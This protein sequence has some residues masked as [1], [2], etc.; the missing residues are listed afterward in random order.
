MK[1]FKKET[2]E[3]ILNDMQKRGLSEPF[4]KL[5]HAMF[6]E[7]ETGRKTMTSDGLSLW[8]G[9]VAAINFSTKQVVQN[10]L[11]TVPGKFIYNTF[12]V[13]GRNKD[14]S[15]WIKRKNTS[16][17]SILTIPNPMAEDSGTYNWCMKII[18]D[19][20]GKVLADRHA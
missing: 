2:I 10:E 1:T 14:V 3:S 20:A 8:E 16:Y 11:Q 6:S 7:F 12:E 18:G 17:T 4:Q 9:S 5:M 19:L 15:I 13:A